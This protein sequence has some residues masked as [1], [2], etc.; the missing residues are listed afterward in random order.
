MIT[1]DRAR[2]LANEPDQDLEMEDD[3]Q[4]QTSSPDTKEH[5]ERLMKW[6]ASANIADDIDPLELMALGQRVIREYDI[7]DSSCSDWLSKIDDAMKLALQQTTPKSYPWP[8]AANVIYPLIT[9]ASQMF[10]ARAYP[11]IINDRNVVKGLVLGRDDGTPE[12]G[13]L[14]PKIDMQTGQPIWLIAPGEK[15]ERAEK[16]GE[17]MSWQLL[18]EQPEWEPQTDRLL[19]ILPIVGC[20]FRKTFFDP[21]RGRNCSFL[22]LAKN[23]RINYYAKSLELAPRVT[24]IVELYPQEIRERELAGLF[25]EIQYSAPQP[26]PGKENA[27]SQ[28]DDDAPQIFLEQHRWEDLDGDGFRE[29]Y[30]VTVHKDSSKVVRIVARYD[31]DGVMYLPD[32]RVGKIDPVQYYTQ[33]DFLPNPEGGIYGLGFGMLLK[34]LNESINTTLNLLIDGG[35]LANVGGGFVGNKL[36]V[37]AG[38]MRF[39]PGEFK[40]LNAAGGTIRENVVQLQFPGPSTVLF[41]LLGLL[42][43]SGKEIAA[44]KDVLMGEQNQ[45]NVPATT[46]LALIEQG[47]QSFTAIYKR[48]HRSLK[49]EFNKLYRLNRIY[50]DDMVDYQIGD[51]WKTITREDYEKGSGVR[52]VSDPTMVSDMQRMARTQFLLNFLNDQRLNGVEILKRAFSEVKIDRP[53]DLFNKGPMMP[54]PEVMLMAQDLDIKKERYQAQQVLDFARA[55]HSMS[56]AVMETGGPEVE[57]LSQKIRALQEM[58]SQ[59]SFA[60]QQQQDNQPPPMPGARKAPDGKWYIPDPHRQGKFMQVNVPGAAE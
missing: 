34:S 49:S 32:G 53:D 33:Y 27:G 58:M 6:I 28:Q 36:S 42:I 26:V 54:S 11:A 35:H 13:P 17:H 48:V 31:E 3:P 2:E 9:T 38:S 10:A 4:D 47:M 43:E 21:S 18:E 14:G 40:Q 19:H 51:D 45:S 23:L 15:A 50:M 59:G 12:F 52:P 22:V 7:D 41:Q 57:E 56:R 25:L 16:I 44:I 46:T 30:I 20:V 1:E 29:P 24:E 8:G 60:N 55:V 5:R 37:S 39:A